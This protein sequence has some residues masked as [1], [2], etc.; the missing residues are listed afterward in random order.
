[1]KRI[2]HL[3]SQLM[4]Y[5]YSSVHQCYE[6]MIPLN[7]GLYLEYPSDEKAYQCPGEFLFGDLLLGAPVT[8]PGEGEQKLVSQEVWLPG[9]E[10]WYHFF[11][12]KAYQGGRT[13]TVESPL[14]EF[15]LF[16]KGATHYLCNLIQNVCV[17]LR[18]P[19]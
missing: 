7:R 12:G 11:T 18:L 5:I 6:D 10:N 13:V 9:G 4:P 17:R 19:S 8:M 2:Y 15:P 16:V 3:R 14:D 1:M